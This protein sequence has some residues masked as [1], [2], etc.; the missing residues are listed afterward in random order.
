[1]SSSREALYYNHNRTNGHRYQI[2]FNT[3]HEIGLHRRTERVDVA[4]S[5]FVR[6]SI[7]VSCQRIIILV[8]DEAFSEFEIAFVAAAL[9]RQEEILGKRVSFIP[10]IGNVLVRPPRLLFSAAQSLF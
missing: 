1:A 7:L 5:M 10:R 4:I 8:I 3:K 6:Q 9:I 2:I